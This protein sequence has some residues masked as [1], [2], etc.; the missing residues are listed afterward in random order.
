MLV[1][2]DSDISVKK[3]VDNFL[4]GVIVAKSVKYFDENPIVKGEPFKIHGTGIDAS[5]VIEKVNSILT[6]CDSQIDNNYLLY[7]LENFK[8]FIGYAVDKNL[9]VMK[10]Y[11]DTERLL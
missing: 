4:L 8:S 5:I 11:A 2:K 9:V 6:H 10:A 1:T 7:F 3:Y